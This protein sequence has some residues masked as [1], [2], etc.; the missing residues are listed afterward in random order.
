[1]LLS[2]FQYIPMVG[3]TQYDM[4]QILDALDGNDS[5]SV[6]DDLPTID[7]NSY[8]MVACPVA[9]RVHEGFWQ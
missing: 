5:G 4:A 2:N 7:L 9:N 6:C 3:L 1:M 8:Y